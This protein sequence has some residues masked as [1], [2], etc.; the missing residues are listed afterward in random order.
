M[1]YKIAGHPVLCRAVPYHAVSCRVV[2]CR[3]VPCRV[4]SCRVVLCCVVPFHA[5]VEFPIQLVGP[6]PHQLSVLPHH[7]CALPHQLLSDL[8]VFWL[9]NG[10][11]AHPARKAVRFEDFLAL[12]ILFLSFSN[13][14][15][16][17]T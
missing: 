11:F 14:N 7:L 10:Y 13:S 15:H 9:Q 5:R 8:S 6:L 17:S 4:V 1:W 12:K 2:L 3:A 16:Q